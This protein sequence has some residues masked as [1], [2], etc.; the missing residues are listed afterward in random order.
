MSE[1]DN[2]RMIEEAF[3][4]LNAHDPDRY[5]KSLDDSYVMESDAFPTP[6]HG[7]EGAKQTLV[8]YFKAFPDLH[9][10][11]EQIITS[12][13]HV[14]ARWHATGTHK[15]EFN[16]ISP[17]NRQVSTRG[18]TVSEIRNG[19]VVKSSMYSDQL[20]LLRQLGVSVGKAAGAAS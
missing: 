19:H 5:V 14:V 11:A 7:R 3:E 10:E 15:G 2:R 20:A 16:N 18:C 1:T 8:M 13:D 4:A 9:F 12:G 17:T 6:V